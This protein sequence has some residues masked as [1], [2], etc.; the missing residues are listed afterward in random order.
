MDIRYEIASFLAKTNAYKAL[1]SPIVIR[2]REKNVFTR[3]VELLAE[4]LL[5]KAFGTSG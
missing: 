5:P 3:I 2:L 1:A 4:I